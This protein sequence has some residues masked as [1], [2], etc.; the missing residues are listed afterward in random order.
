MQNLIDELA[1]GYIQSKYN[2]KYLRE[3]IKKTLE[4]IIPYIRII[5]KNKREKE[6]I[7]LW[8]DVKEDKEVERLFK[9]LLKEVDRPIIIYV[10]SKFKNNRYFGIK[11]IKEALK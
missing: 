9:E 1:S 4:F 7:I 3:K 10:A 5:L 11:I 6:P 8:N 2:E